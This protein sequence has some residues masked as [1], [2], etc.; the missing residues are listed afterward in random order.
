MIYNNISCNSQYSRHKLLRM[1]DFR[2]NEAAELLGVSPDTVRRMADAGTL[3][4][5][6]TS[7]GQRRIHGASLAEYLAKQSEADPDER[8][9]EQSIR[10][11]LPGV[12]LRVIKDTVAAK[13]EM[14]VGPHR[15]VA[16]VTREAVDALGL[17]P[18]ARAVAS[19]KSTN[20]SIEVPKPRRRRRTG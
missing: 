2:I 12:V 5:H 11:R 19:V 8:L 13:V 20:L 15:L 4:A 7:G 6:R 1:P 16:L 10:N 14:Q 9:R 3:D 18:G 17:E